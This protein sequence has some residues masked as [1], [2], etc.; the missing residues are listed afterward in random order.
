MKLKIFIISFGLCLVTGTGFAQ[1]KK[2]AKSIISE[3][4]SINKYH[5]KQELDRMQKGELIDLYTE[6]NKVLVRTLPYIAF[7]TKPGVTM[8]TLGIPNDSDNRKGL[9]DQFEN[10]DDYLEKSTEF[11]NVYLPYSDTKNLI[12]AI[13][14]YE[15]IMKSLHQYSEFR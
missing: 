5:N 12:A 7:A 9:D 15:E 2:E 1:K 10:T 13:L 8:T 11:H 3:K 4:I 14:F 6:R